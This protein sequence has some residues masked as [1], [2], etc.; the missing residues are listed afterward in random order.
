MMRDFKIIN[1]D[2]LDPFAGT[3]TTLKVALDLGRSAIGIEL[4]PKDCEYGRKCCEKA[5]RQ[6]NLF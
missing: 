4:N 2:V 1:A 6:Q 5:A 3:A